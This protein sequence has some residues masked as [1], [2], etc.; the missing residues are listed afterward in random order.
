[1][2]SSADAMIFGPLGLETVFCTAAVHPQACQH[3]WCD[4]QYQLVL[5]FIVSVAGTIAFWLD[6]SSFSNIQASHLVRFL[7]MQSVTYMPQS[8]DTYT[9]RPM[10]HGSRH[11]ADEEKTQLVTFS[12]WNPRQVGCRILQ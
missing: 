3:D 4:V 11:A 10:K 7:I 5:Q 6:G 12:E 2:A 8:I 1:L 9:T